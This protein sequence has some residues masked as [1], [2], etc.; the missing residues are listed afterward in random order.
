MPGPGRLRT[1]TVPSMEL[2][3]L[4]D[5]RNPPSSRIDPADLYRRTLDHVRAVEDLGFDTVWLT[6]HHFIDDDYL[7]SV[8]P[9]A[10]AVAA[11]T[12]R[13]TIGTAVLLL[14][15]HDPLRVAEDAAV[16]DV[17][18]GGRL[19]L[20]LGIGYKVEE[21]VAF[22]VDRRRRGALLDEG[23]GVLR[24]AW[25]DG[26]VPGR[27]VEVTPKPVHEE[28]IPIWLAGRAEVP[29]RRA[30]RRGDGLIAVGEL[31]LHD[32]YLAERAA[33]GR[34]GRA[35]LCTFVQRYPTD[36]PERADAELGEHAAYR[37]LRYADWYGTAADLPADEVWRER[38][39][40][41]D[42]ARRRRFVTPD[43]LVAEL[44][45]LAATGVDTVL[46]FGTLPGAAPEATLPLFE[47]IA[48]LRPRLPSMT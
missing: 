28:G 27:G 7:P 46:W 47:Q 48:A 42:A 39:L 35:N 30:A 33:A 9:M 44:E 40:A 34:T 19:R 43:E 37:D 38:A 4:Y 5:F 45:A 23:L 14:P 17:V 24:A 2:G 11:V 25:S 1:A 20:G 31:G 41:T 18:S 26:P 29:V 13:V 12:S 3:V 36:D 8:L 22:D 16:V 15:L 32:V 10:A 21:F 6:E